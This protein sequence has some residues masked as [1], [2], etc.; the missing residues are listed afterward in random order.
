[1]A[2][3]SKICIVS[4]IG[5]SQFSQGQTKA[6][7][8]NTLLQKNIFKSD[9]NLLTRSLKNLSCKKTKSELEDDEENFHLETHFDHKNKVMYIHYESIY[10]SPQLFEV[11]VNNFD[12][13]K[14]FYELW[15]NEQLK[16]VKTILLLFS[17]SHIILISNPSCEFD[18][19]YIRFFRIVDLLR[20]K[21]LPTVV[22]ILKSLDIQINKDWI[23]AAR[24]CSPRVL[25]TF[26]N[27]SQ[28]ILN[29]SDSKQILEKLQH[30]LEDQIY[31]S[32]RKSYVITN[33]SNNSL[34]S[35]PAN[36]EFVYIHRY[37]HEKLSSN[38]FLLSG[39]QKDLQRDANLEKL[40]NIE[41]KNFI[42]EHINTAL[43]DGF[44]DNI[45]RTH[46]APVFELPTVNTWYK[47]YDA[48]LDFFLNEPKTTKIQTFYSQ[49][50]D[51]IDIDVQFSEK[52][53]KK[54]L[55]NA[56]NL[57]QENLPAHYS[58]TQHEQKLEMAINFFH[59]NARGPMFNFYL[60]QLKNKCNEI[61]LNGRRLCEAV[62]LTGHNC[63]NELHYLPSLDQKEEPEEPLE[64]EF[65]PKRTEKNNR[66]E[67]ATL[68][69]NQRSK[70]Y[71]IPTKSHNSN[72]ITISASNC[73]EFQRER[74]DPFDLNEANFSFYEDF[75]DMELIRNK[76]LKTYD[77]KEKCDGEK[78]TC[79]MIHSEIPF[80]SLPKF[81]SWSLVAIGNYSD[82]N[83]STGLSQP[84]FMTNHNYLIPWD[85][86]ILNGQVSSLYAKH[87]SKKNSEK[88][89]S[90]NSK[91]LELLDKQKS[92][93]VTIKAF[94]GLEY[95]CPLGHRFICSGPDR[96][97]RLS[98][99]GN[100]KDDAY[101]LLN[102]D[103]PLYT[104]C[105][106]RNAKESPPYM[107]QAMRLFVVTPPGN[108]IE[109]TEDKKMTK[110]N[111]E[112]KIHVQPNPQPC[113][114]FWPTFEDTIVL[115]DNSIWVLRLPYI[116]MSEEGKP[117]YRP[118]NFETLNN[119]KILKGMFSTVVNN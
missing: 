29:L 83:S 63:V 36:Q 103:M 34:F 3:D 118:K 71:K 39:P 91:D 6:W 92:R 90:K 58:K 98:S 59:H 85:L 35:I 43:T 4:L 7:K 94:I 117:F 9:P 100:V 97:V 101:K 77:F 25:F 93:T 111:I 70:T 96:I 41:F 87:G 60:N 24:P 14:N 102:C 12:E 45:G 69:L 106:C 116:Y 28:N 52:R 65:E 13:E 82:Y 72:I 30:S 27:C 108:V 95:E 64:S 79:L 48:L 11:L 57:Y 44:N 110:I 67:D 1:M 26:E 37:S 89:K 80:N 53:C 107:A 47:I 5:K 19:S 74:K 33:I 50:K 10:D 15:E 40:D 18:I 78:L 23:Y 49:L 8:L 113:P 109:K 112:L 99:N 46:V 76:I 32:L 86:H 114:I 88:V 84:G 51:Q 38:R 66:L 62:S 20:N 21:M 73:G 31:N 104:A 61:W 75:S 42:F 115:E 68:L 105:P 2:N 22:E 55:P 119:C 56:I 16:Y 17:I 54:V 81:N